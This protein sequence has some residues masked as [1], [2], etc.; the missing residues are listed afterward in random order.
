MT[1]TANKLSTLHELPITI[2]VS[3]KFLADTIIT[4][5]EGG[6]GSSWFPVAR[7]ITDD[8]PVEKSLQTAWKKSGL[9][10]DTVVMTP[11]KGNPEHMVW[12]EYIAQNVARGGTLTFFEDGEDEGEPDTYTLH[13]LTREKL[14]KGLAMVVKKYPHLARLMDIDEFGGAEYDLD[15]IGADAVIQCALLDGLVYG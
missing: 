5:I 4:A 2:K 15:A 9:G 10:N 12:N 8:D 13:R 11:W 1:K 3:E 14:L 6:F 7:L